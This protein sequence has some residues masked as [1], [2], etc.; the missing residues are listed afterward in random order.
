MLA[1]EKVWMLGDPGVV[2]SA[3][4]KGRYLALKTAE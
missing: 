3:A 4:M 1:A 2:L